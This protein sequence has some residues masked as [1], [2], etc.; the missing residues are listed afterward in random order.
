MTWTAAQSDRSMTGLYAVRSPEAP[1]SIGHRDPNLERLADHLVVATETHAMAN[2]IAMAH[3]H[4]DDLEDPQT[5]ET[6]RRALAAFDGLCNE[7]GATIIPESLT[8]TPDLDGGCWGLRASF[9]ATTGQVVHRRVGVALR[10]DGSSPEEAV[11]FIV[12]APSLVR[13]RLAETKD[14]VVAVR[15]IAQETIVIDAEDAAAF[16]THDWR[17]DGAD[18]VRR[19]D[20]ERL[21][22]LLAGADGIW[23]RATA[24]SITGITKGSAQDYRKHKLVVRPTAVE[25]R[26]IQVPPVIM[27]QLRD[28]AR[29]HD[30]DLGRAIASM[31]GATT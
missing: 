9:K 8:G 14:G 17:A 18:I 19:D 29:A 27:D 30:G 11:S 16:D 26:G 23:N 28:A 15:H 3:N 10:G 2:F 20:G 22:D 25:A 21:A 1:A 31:L 6:M 13:R 5:W 7:V 12:Q 24:P 4:A